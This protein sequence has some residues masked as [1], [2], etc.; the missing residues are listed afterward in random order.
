MACQRGAVVHSEPSRADAVWLDS[1][2]FDAVVQQLVMEA[3]KTEL[4]I[5]PRPMK[6]DPTIVSLRPI[7]AALG[8]G[9]APDSIYDNSYPVLQ[10][11]RSRALG[12]GSVRSTDATLTLQCPGVLRRSNPEIRDERA[13]HCP[14]DTRYEAL[15][16]LPRAGG[17][18]IPGG[19]DERATFGDG[20]FTVRVIVRT[21]GPQGV[22]ESCDDRVFRFIDGAWKLVVRRDLLVVE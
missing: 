19:V 5:D 16:A 7:G 13:R 1:V 12:R 15:I 21:L 20:V 8:F 3:S 18:F 17:P 10:G 14:R 2:L 22:S 4:R 9:T 6:P 11:S